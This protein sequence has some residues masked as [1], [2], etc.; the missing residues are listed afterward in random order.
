MYKIDEVKNSF[1]CDL[2]KKILADPVVM[3]CGS[4]ICKIH[5]NRMIN[6]SCDQKDIL[7]CE[8]C[9]EE[10]H[11]PKNGFVVNNRLKKLLKLELKSLKFDCPVFDD[12]KKGLEKAKENMLKV[13]E[14]EKNGEMFIYNYFEDIKRQVDLRRE[15]LK[16]NIDNYSDEMIKSVEKTQ[17]D[18]IKRKGANQITAFIDKSRKKLDLITERFDTFEY[19][20]KKF[21]EIKSTVTALNKELQEIIVEYQDLL[22]LKKDYSFE[23]VES[24]TEH[25]FGRLIGFEVIFWDRFIKTI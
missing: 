10:H 6:N 8:I 7:I 22:I 25:I 9:Q 2:C 16:Q 24:P 18:L 15:I 19:N 5:I 21:K 1:D 14:L 3:P 23:F 11:I 13:E 20:Y 12:C 4:F 17:T